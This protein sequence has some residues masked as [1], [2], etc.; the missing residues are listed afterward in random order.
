ME[1]AFA[2]SL[3]EQNIFP[4]DPILNLLHSFDQLAL[5]HPM[6][7]YV[8]S[9]QF[10]QNNSNFYMSATL[11]VSQI[12]FRLNV[13]WIFRFQRKLQQKKVVIR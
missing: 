2:T 12:N 8:R 1:I 13:F 6:L 3:Y 7:T 11:F 5:K 10:K 9:A 4:F